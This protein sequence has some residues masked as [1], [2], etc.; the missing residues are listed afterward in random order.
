[1]LAMFGMTEYEPSR[2]LLL[3]EAPPHCHAAETIDWRPV[4]SGNTL[5]AAQANAEAT[6]TYQ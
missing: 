2:Y 6:A 5:A 1:V 3:V 4:R